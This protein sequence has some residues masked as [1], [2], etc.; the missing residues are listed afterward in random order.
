MRFVNIQ[1]RA[2]F[3]QFDENAK[4]HFVILD[5]VDTSYTDYRPIKV[6]MWGCKLPGSANPIATSR[7][8]CCRS[9]HR[10]A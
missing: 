2:F 4:Q 10:S 9:N 3:D 8:R 7:A 5:R 1:P 6:G